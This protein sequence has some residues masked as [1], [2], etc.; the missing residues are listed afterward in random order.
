[1]AEFTLYQNDPPVLYELF[2]RT[3]YHCGRGND[4]FGL[5]N[6]D[7]YY[8]DENGHLEASAF[9]GIW[10]ALYLLK[11]QI[12]NPKDREFISQ[13]VTNFE[14]NPTGDYFKLISKDLFEFLERCKIYEFPHINSL[15]YNI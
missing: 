8:L 6:T 7:M 11:S 2:L 13:I 5:A 10:T 1:M 12:N 9:V 3:V 15:S 4:P 14:H